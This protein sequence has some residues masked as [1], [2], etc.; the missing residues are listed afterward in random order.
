MT[1]PPKL[2]LQVVVASGAPGGC[3][4]GPAGGPSRRKRRR[5][6]GEWGGTRRKATGPAV[7]HLRRPP[8]VR[9]GPGPDVDG[10]LRLPC[11]QAGWGRSGRWASHV[12]SLGA[13]LLGQGPG[14]P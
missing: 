6:K 10:G 8:P 11:R 5:R 4:A 13:V 9:P 1:P 14:G 12:D 2:G 3:G 7:P